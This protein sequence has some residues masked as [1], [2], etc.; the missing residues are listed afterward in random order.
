MTTG[1]S[2]L[3]TN[4]R[5]PSIIPALST[6]PIAMNQYVVGVDVGGTTVKMAL[7]QSEA[8]SQSPNSGQAM[9]QASSHRIVRSATI[10]T[11]P[12]DPGVETARR[13]AAAVKELITAASITRIDGVGVGCPG[14]VNNVDGSI[15]VSANLPGFRNL[16]L[17]A[18]LEKDL[19]VRVALQ[20]DANAAALGEYQFGVSARGCQNM[21]LLTLGTGVGGGVI[22]NGKLLVGADN[23]AGE[24]GHVKVDFSEAAALCGCGR[25]GCVEAYAGMEGIER[26]ARTI[27]AQTPSA[28]LSSDTL[29][30]KLITQAASDG[31]AMAKAILHRVG[32]YLGRAIANFIDIF[33]PEEVILAGGASRA[34]EFFLPGIRQSMQEL[35]SFA[36]TRDRVSIE[37]S[38]IPD[39][40][41][42]LGAA[43]VFLN[44]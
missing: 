4:Q 21:V 8:N 38:A 1:I 16:P 19:G 44:R 42:V 2:R 10:D 18:L 35:C 30:T 29:S 9:R 15:V 7:V 26:T 24:L 25:K 5:L 40:I 12:Q 43:A 22:C 11:R 33:N 27:L 13:I 17:G 41:N 37:A 31:D 6:E 23:A 34:T 32:Q 20:N 36:A 39:D 28:A 14:L 3:S